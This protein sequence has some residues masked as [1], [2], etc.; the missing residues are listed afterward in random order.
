MAKR[1][2]NKDL[3]FTVEETAF[4]LRRTQKSVL[5]D[6]R[7]GNIKTEKNTDPLRRQWKVLIPGAE[8]GRILNGN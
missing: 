2:F 4:L 3:Y 8:I 7:E 6:I 5:K 1:Y